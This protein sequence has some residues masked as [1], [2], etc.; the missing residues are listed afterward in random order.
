MQCDLITTEQL[1]EMGKNQVKQFS[2]KLSKLQKDV[3]YLQQLPANKI[4]R[5]LL[6]GKIKK[7]RS[8]IQSKLNRGQEHPALYKVIWL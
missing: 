1:E 3:N 5:D 7:K 6:V 8:K 4:I 2:S